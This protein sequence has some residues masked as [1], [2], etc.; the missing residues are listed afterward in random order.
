[1]SG[2]TTTELIELCDPRLAPKY[3]P[4]L[5]RWLLIRWRRYEPAAPRIFVEN[6]DGA[7]LLRDGYVGERHD[8][9]LICARLLTV[10]SKPRAELGSM[11]LPHTFEP[12]A[13]FW[14]DYVAR[15]R[16]ALDPEHKTSFIDERWRVDGDTREC[17]WCGARQVR[18]VWRET[19]EYSRWRVA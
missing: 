17:L 5:H 9:S 19:V 1:M 11:M 15:G 14:P 8:G 2:L 10:L 12:V 18:K 4:N 13:E 16:C 7:T 6:C 3:S